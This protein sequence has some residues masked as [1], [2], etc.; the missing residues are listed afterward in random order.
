MKMEQGPG[1]KQTKIGDTPFKSQK[2]REAGMF[3]AGSLGDI[4]KEMGSKKVDMEAA[5]LL[6][7]RHRSGEDKREIQ[8]KEKAKRQKAW[9]KYREGW[10][11][12]QVGDKLGKMHPD[13]E[14]RLDQR[15]EFPDGT[16]EFV[17]N[18]NS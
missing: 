6:I 14:G 4:A 10:K 3:R 8:E 15:I 18:E 9:W 12:V 11:S 7:R 16:M 2:N 5:K 13:Y 1:K 17:K